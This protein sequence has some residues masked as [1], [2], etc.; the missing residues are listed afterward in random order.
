MTSS[1]ITEEEE[2]Y[3]KEFGKTIHPPKAIEKLSEIDR[4]D[5]WQHKFAVTKIAET[6]ESEFI[7]PRT[8]HD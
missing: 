8:T 3:P 7:T 6:S 1:G 2:K 4:G 5:D